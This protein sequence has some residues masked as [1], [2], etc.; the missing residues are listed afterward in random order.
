M[1]VGSKVK[2]GLMMGMLMCACA[3]FSSCGQA[4]L[5]SQ[6]EIVHAVFFQTN[7]RESTALLL[8]ADQPKEQ[9]GETT[10]YK[11]AVGVGQTPAQALEQA[12]RSLDGQ[13]FYGVMDMA[14]LPLEGDWQSTVELGR[15]LYEKA[16]PAPQITLFLMES[17][18]QKELT[19][20][21]AA[22]YEGMENAINK[23]GLCNGL[24]LMFSAQNECALPVWQGTEYGFVFLQKDRPNTVLKDTLPA[25]L[26]AV[27]CGQANRMDCCFSQGTAS[28]QG[29]A[30][31]QHRVRE[32]GNAEL[33]LTL[34]VPDLQE[35]GT[36]R[37]SGEQLEQTLREELKHAFAQITTNCCVPEFDP[38]RMGVW[39]WA[40]RGQTDE[41]PPLS[42]EVSFES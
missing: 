33:Y 41:L 11:T 42:L 25:Q 17:R 16:Q 29:K 6:R 31:V 21:A 13:V 19:E 23:Y 18:T 2:S 27:L 4:P 3:L 9:E 26:A 7:E 1:A 10:G 8:L 38:L 20:E 39:V 34:D 24:Q 28:V 35:L 32:Q 30:M 36:A 5:L 12:E 37:R 15:L 22:L 14:V 40:A